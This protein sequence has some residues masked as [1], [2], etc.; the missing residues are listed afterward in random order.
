MVL[1]AEANNDTETEG[2][3]EK[4]AP[5]AVFEAWVTYLRFHTWSR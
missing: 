4:I 5:V 2:Q 3:K 1:T